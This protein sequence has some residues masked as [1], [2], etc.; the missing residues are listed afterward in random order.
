M[1]KAVESWVDH[2]DE[3][4]GSIAILKA[5]RDTVG[6][7]RC[8]EILEFI[9]SEKLI[10]ISIS[11]GKRLVN[12]SLE[13]NLI[14]FVIAHRHRIL[15]TSYFLLLTEGGFPCCLVSLKRFKKC[16]KASMLGLLLLFRCCGFDHLAV[17]F[18]ICIF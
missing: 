9:A 10:A 17:I 3:L 6:V 15:F 14:L 13:K 4:V 5:F 11:S 12:L 1:I 7:H 16:H 18:V 2:V 8:D